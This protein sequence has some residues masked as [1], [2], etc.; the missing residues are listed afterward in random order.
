[1]DFSQCSGV[2]LCPTQLPTPYTIL[3]QT[4]VQIITDVRGRAIFALQVTG[5]CSGAVNIYSSGML[6]TLPIYHA[7]PPIINVDQDGDGVVT[8]ADQQILAA[9]AP[10]DPLGDLN[11]DGVCNAADM[12]VL[13]AHLGHQCPSSA[14][15][16]RTTTWGSVKIRYH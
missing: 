14:V 1:M 11:C 3:S 9:R 13:T 8:A 6:L 10:S 5:V 16:N 12:A 15:P 7:M 2:S 4:R